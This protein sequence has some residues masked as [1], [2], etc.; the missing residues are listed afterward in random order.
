[1]HAR[2]PPTPSA[3]AGA[4]LA[5]AAPNLSQ[6]RRSP[7]DAGACQNMAAAPEE[8]VDRRPIRRVRS[9]SDTPYINEARISLHLET[10]LTVPIVLRCTLVNGSD[11]GFGQ[12]LPCSPAYIPAIHAL[13]SVQGTVGQEKPNCP[14]SKIDCRCSKQT[15]P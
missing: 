11:S 3:R 1:M 2:P 14:Y 7:V 8:E 15:P 5:A 12:S 9:K 10:G 6:S 4:R 13:C